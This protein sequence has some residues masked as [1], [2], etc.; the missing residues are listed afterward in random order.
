[1]L[2]NLQG[3]G[4]DVKSVDLTGSCD[5]ETPEPPVPTLAAAAAA[6]PVSARIKRGMVAPGGSSS[7]VLG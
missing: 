7:L 3:Q 4:L 6:A 5:T 2:A 1:M